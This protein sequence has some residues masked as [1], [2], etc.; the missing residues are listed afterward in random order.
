MDKITE[1]LPPR[2]QEGTFSQVDGTLFKGT[3][4]QKTRNRPRSGK[5][6]AGA[7]EA[8]WTKTGYVVKTDC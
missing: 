8:I 4:A 6:V 2:N 5:G 7:R 1:H 3:V